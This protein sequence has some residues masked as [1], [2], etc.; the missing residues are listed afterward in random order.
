[1]STTVKYHRDGFAEGRPAINVK[2][3]TSHQVMLPDGFQA[4]YANGTVHL[5][6]IAG[7][8]IDAAAAR[9][10]SDF[11]QAAEEM[12]DQRGLGGIEQEGRSGGWLVFTDSDP[13]DEP[14]ADKAAHWLAGYRAMTEWADAYIAAAPG[15]V[16]RLAQQYAMDEAGNSAAR[17]MFPTAFGG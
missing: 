11:W 2:C 14:D 3:Y 10:A 5:D 1:M 17:R 6:D 12:A 8:L 16:S 7:D 15:K 13:D 4:A 9:V